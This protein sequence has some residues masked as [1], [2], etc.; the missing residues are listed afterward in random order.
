MR[1]PAGFEMQKHPLRHKFMYRIGLSLATGT[2]N[3]AYLLLIRN[4][5]TLNAASGI[6]VNPKHANFAVET[7]T[8]CAPNSIIDRLTIKLDFSYTEDN[9]SKSQGTSCKLWW[10]PIFFSFPE[11][12]DAAD[13]VS[14]TTVAAIL[15]L[16]KDATEEDVTPLY[17][18]VKHSTAGSSD[19]L[20][21]VSTI[22]KT[23]TFGMLNMDT[24]LATEGVTWDDDL[25]QS[26]MQ[27][28][29]NKGALKACLGRRRYMTLSGNHRHKSYYIAK[30]PPRAVRRIVPYSFMAILVHMPLIS[31]D[32][33]L[34]HSLS[35]DATIAYVGVTAKIRYHEWNN[36]HHQ[37]LI[38]P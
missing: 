29:T 33:Q 17:N 7:G 18:N 5:K 21:A 36:E 9:Q 6:E 3:S 31:D 1:T 25:L 14:T 8:M 35:P 11:K 32:D 20:Q 15:Q 24:S 26:A 38:G 2:I 34:Y 23:E 13:D 19:K 27:Y 22:N 16:V 30:K 28:Y 4:Y 10:Q 37:E 12:L